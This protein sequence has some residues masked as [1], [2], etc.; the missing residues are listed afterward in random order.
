[1][2]G[3]CLLASRTSAGDGLIE[4]AIEAGALTL[5]A[6]D[7]RAF[8]ECQPHQVV[9]KQGLKARLRAIEDSDSLAPRFTD[10]RLDDAAA[11]RDAQ[12]HRRNRQG[13]RERIARGV[14]R[15]PRP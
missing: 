5:E 1:M 11:Q 4:R 13:T 2:G 6:R 12:F 8:H 15:E 14:N 10:L 9:K 7:I 3:S